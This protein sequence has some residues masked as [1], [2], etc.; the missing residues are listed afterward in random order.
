MQPIKAERHFPWYVDSAD[1]DNLDCQCGSK[2]DGIAGWATHISTELTRGTAMTAVNM[3][4]QIHDAT[5]KFVAEWTTGYLADDIAAKLRCEEVEALAELL[6]AIGHTEA[7]Q[8]WLT[9]HAGGDD[10]GDQH[11]ICAHC[12]P[13]AAVSGQGNLQ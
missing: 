11:C 9:A 2:C 1:T 4:A 7:A 10:C 5:D 12:A 13:P 8:Y 6:T 3:F